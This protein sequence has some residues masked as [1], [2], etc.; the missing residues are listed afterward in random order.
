MYV[1]CPNIARALLMLVAQPTV[2][3]QCLRF[4]QFLARSDDGTQRAKHRQ[5]CKGYVHPRAFVGVLFVAVLK[6]SAQQARVGGMA[7]VRR[8]V[9]RY[10][11]VQLDAVALADV[12]HL[13]HR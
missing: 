11:G 7:R 6:A 9:V 4:L 13:A 5:V 10:R 8:S 1:H 3:A 12:T 2:H